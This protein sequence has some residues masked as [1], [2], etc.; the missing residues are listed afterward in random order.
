MPYNYGQ[1]VNI[2]DMTDEQYESY[3][4]SMKAQM[5]KK[6][7]EPWELTEPLL[8]AFIIMAVFTG[9]YYLSLWIEQHV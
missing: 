9:C 4:N 8:G 5:E 1:R 3:S 2:E 6:R 7:N